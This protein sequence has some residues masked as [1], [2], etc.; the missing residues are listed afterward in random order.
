MFLMH[1]ASVLYVPRR[2]GLAVKNRADGCGCGAGPGA[3]TTL[4]RPRRLRGQREPPLQ[5][6]G[7]L[8]TRRRSRWGHHGDF[9]VIFAPK[10]HSSGGRDPIACRCCRRRL[11]LPRPAAS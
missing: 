7:E 10:F 1:S 11:G 6:N 2:H 3:P 9:V 8:A 4:T 5:L